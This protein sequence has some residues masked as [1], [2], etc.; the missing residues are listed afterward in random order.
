MG[1]MGLKTLRFCTE[2]QKE[3]AAKVSVAKRPTLLWFMYS[4][5]TVIAIN[6][7][8]SCKQ[9]GLYFGLHFSF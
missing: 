6:C 9:I 1:C 7:I 3:K 5:L 2:K 8:M 4:M